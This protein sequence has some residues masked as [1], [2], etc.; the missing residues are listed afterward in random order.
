MPRRTHAKFQLWKK[1]DI[2]WLSQSILS[3]VR[4][5]AGLAWLRLDTHMTFDIWKF[6][7]R[8]VQNALQAE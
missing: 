7:E 1:L 8:R 5:S 2:M 6:K 3:Y 4:L